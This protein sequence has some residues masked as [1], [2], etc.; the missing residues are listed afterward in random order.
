M[1]NAGYRVPSFWTH[2]SDESGARSGDTNPPLVVTSRVVVTPVLMAVIAGIFLVMVANGVSLLDPSAS[3]L[4]RWGADYGPLTTNGQPWRILTALF[5][6]VGLVHLCFNLL[7]LGFAGILSERLFGHAAFAVLYLLSG[8]GGAVASLAW[9]PF[10]VSGGASGALFGIIGGLAAFRVFH[11]EVMRGRRDPV[12]TR[13]ELFLLCSLPLMTE[14]GIDLGAHLG[15][16]VTGLVVGCGLFSMPGTATPNARLARTVIVV[17][18][19]LAVAFG[20]TLALRKVNDLAIEATPLFQLDQ[21]S[22]NLVKNSVEQIES[23]RVERFNELVEKDLLPP[24][25]AA[26]DRLA[27][28]RFSEA[29]QPVANAMLEYMRLRAESWSLAVTALRTNDRGL[30]SAF[31]DKQ[32]KADAIG[33]GIRK[34]VESGLACGEL[35]RSGLPSPSAE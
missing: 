15:G 33:A 11:P 32:R 21:R 12:L 30:L 29:Q 27:K 4:K 2:D 35:R 23:G 5:V 13:F 3:D 8:I 28:L 20:A 10:Y 17:A 9:H 6:H 26:R 16:L 22:D 24:W 18:A 1:S 19:G 14:E 7:L 25:N 31:N 34:S